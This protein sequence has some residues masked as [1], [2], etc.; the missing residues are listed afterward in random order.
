[1]RK[2]DK[3]ILTDLKRFRVMRRDD[4]IDLHFNGLKSPITSCNTVMKRLRRDGFVKAVTDRNQ[5]LYMHEETNIKKDSTKI[6]H[7]LRIVEFYRELCKIEKPRT[8]EVEPKITEKGGVEPDIF[9]I[10]KAAPFYVEIQRNK[11]SSKVFNAKIERYE[12]Y[13][14]SGEWQYERWQPKD[15]KYFPHVWVITDTLY[16]IDKRP[17]HTFQSSNVSEFLDS[18]KK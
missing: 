5:Y 14:H 4:I 10:W 1:M 3:A 6:P 17:F 13:F 9:M 7:F 18:I 2:R 8:F 15:K 11:Y 12:Q 16:N